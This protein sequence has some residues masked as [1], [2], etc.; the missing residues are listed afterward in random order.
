MGEQRNGCILLYTYKGNT[1]HVHIIYHP[2]SSSLVSGST[3]EYMY[4]IPWFN[5]PLCLPSYS[6][7]WAVIVYSLVCFRTT[8]IKTLLS[9]K[10]TS[11]VI[12]VDVSS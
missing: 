8:A 7:V 2:S 4:I 12:T 3:H 11:R 5:E 9:Y 6:I 1:N 10:S